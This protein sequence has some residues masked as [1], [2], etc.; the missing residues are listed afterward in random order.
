MVDFRKNY[1]IKCLFREPNIKMGVTVDIFPKIK[2]KG[3]KS[4]KLKHIV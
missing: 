2:N 4:R 3:Y 1:P